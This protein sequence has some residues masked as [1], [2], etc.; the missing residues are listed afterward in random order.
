MLECP[1]LAAALGAAVKTKKDDQKRVH[2][3]WKTKN[4]ISTFALLPSQVGLLL[5]F[6][7]FLHSFLAYFFK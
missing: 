3:S 1:L 2:L 7:L 5:S 4:A 6:L